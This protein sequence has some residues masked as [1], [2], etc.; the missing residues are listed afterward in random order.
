MAKRAPDLS[1]IPG[2]IWQEAERR[3]AVLR[4]LAAL[5]VCPRAQA[6]AAAATLGVTERQVYRLLRRCREGG[7]TL[8]AMVR[9]GSS[10]GRGKGRIAERRDALIRE[11]VAD[12]YLTPQRLSAARVVIEVCRRARE[13]H[14]PPPSASTVRRRI[15]ALSLEQRCHRGDVSV[16]VA[17]RGSTTTAAAP[18]DMVQIDHTPVDLILVDPIERLPIGRPWVTVA[19]DVFSRCIAGFHITLEAPSATSVG[20]CLAQVGSDKRP[21]LEG[22]GVDAEWPVVGCPRRLGVDNAAEFHSEALERGCAQHDI[23]IDWRPPGRC[24]RRR[25]GDL[26]PARARLRTRRP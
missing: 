3:T 18:L 4:P 6:R 9:S 14:V 24:L 23:T 16:P 15:A 22:I 26:L 1:L 5:P 17:V 10:G 20:L 11:A 13:L 2:P 8:T 21:W 12:L 7:G 25:L 19:I